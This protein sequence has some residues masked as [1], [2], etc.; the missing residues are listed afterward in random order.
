MAT[1]STN[2]INQYYPTLQPLLANIQNIVPAG[3]TT[4]DQQRA[5]LETIANKYTAESPEFKQQ[6][7]SSLEDQVDKYI[8]ITDKLHDYNEIFNTNT[9]INKELKKEQKRI[10]DITRDLKNQ[11]YISK[12]KSQM[13]EYDT[14]KLNFYRGILLVSS[15][16]ILELFALVA[17]Q[18]TNIIGSKVFYWIVSISGLVY[19]AVIISIVYANSFRS[20]TDWNKFQWGIINGDKTSDQTCS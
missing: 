5:A 3:T 18:L 1:V 12:Q 11:I 2:Q 4:T 17:A 9:Y 16:V 14:N 6:L 15:F 10:N 7:T 13:Y 19:L 8:G 20:N